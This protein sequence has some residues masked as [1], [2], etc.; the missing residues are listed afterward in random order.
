MATT[1]VEALDA[2]RTTYD[3]AHKGAASYLQARLAEKDSKLDEHFEIPVIDLAP[4]FSTSLGDRQAVA[5]KI[6][7]ACTTS[8]FFYIANHGVSQDA[9]RNVLEQAQRFFGELSMEQKEKLHVKKSKLGLGWE[10]SEYTSI[11]GDEERKEG[12]NFSY[13][14]ALDPSGGDGLYRNLDG[15]NY[16]GNLWPKDKDLP[17][18]HAGVKM[19]Y[20]AVSTPNL[21]SVIVSCADRISGAGVG[22]SPLS[23]LCS[24]ARPTRRVL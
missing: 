2:D 8:G 22:A 20:G 15:S 11:A 4:S 24:F 3:E 23:S 5:T 18:F 19:Y 16:N 10:P 6:R 12:F 17:G 13:E 9:E 14:D 7:K 1:R 21:L